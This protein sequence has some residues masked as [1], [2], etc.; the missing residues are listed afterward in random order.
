MAN[1]LN[2]YFTEVGQ[3]LAAKIDKLKQIKQL[4][5]SE[6]KGPDKIPL[7]Y[8]NMCSQIL[9]PIL[10]ILGSGYS[11]KSS[12][13]EKNVQKPDCMFYHCDVMICHAICISITLILNFATAIHSVAVR[14]LE[15]Y[16]ADSGFEARWSHYIFNEIE[17]HCISFS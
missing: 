7:K 9:S 11:T 14:A 16:A 6:S 12:L 10:K 5:P 4:K 1:L 2:S 15:S 3:K 17:S 13:L 8:I